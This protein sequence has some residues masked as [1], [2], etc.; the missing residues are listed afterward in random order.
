M[1]GTPAA[2]RVLAEACASQEGMRSTVLFFFM[3][4]NVL[5]IPSI[6]TY[7][8]LNH[9]GIYIDIIRKRYS[10]QIL[11]QLIAQ[12]VKKEPHQA[13]AVPKLDGRY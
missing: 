6:Q 1:Q 11:T 2:A 12:L 7:I 9:Q 10:A 8:L 3:Q 4:L 13:L 5:A